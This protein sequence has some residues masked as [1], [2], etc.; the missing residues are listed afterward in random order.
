M[1]LKAFKVQMDSKAFRAH[2][3]LMVLKAF[4]VQTDSKVY[5]AH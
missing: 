1:V 3:V 4:K 2:K 5:K